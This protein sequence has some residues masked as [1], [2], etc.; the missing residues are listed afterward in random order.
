MTTLTESIKPFSFRREE[1][2]IGKIVD[3]AF[4]QDRKFW[5]VTKDAR[6]KVKRSYEGQYGK[7]S[8]V[9][10]YTVEIPANY[11]LAIACKWLDG[12][13]TTLIEENFS[14]LY[15]PSVKEDVVACCGK[16]EGKKLSEIAAIDPKYLQWVSRH[17]AVFTKN[18]NFAVAVQ[19][20]LAA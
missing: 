2:A 10:H 4:V 5:N 15:E 1:L 17:A 14:V 7:A 13:G 3:G 8:N 20:F 16:H 19:A 6:L 11:D 12:Q 9:H 18:R